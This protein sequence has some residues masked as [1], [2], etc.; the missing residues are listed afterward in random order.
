MK[1]TPK[2]RGF[3]Q[4]LPVVLCKKITLLDLNKEKAVSVIIPPPNK[5]M[6]Q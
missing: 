5:T 2:I 6:P 1:E 3:P 4:Q